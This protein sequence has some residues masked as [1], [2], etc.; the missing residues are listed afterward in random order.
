MAK[1]KAELEA[2]SYRHRA[3]VAEARAELQRGEFQKA[4]QTAVSAWQHVD[5]MMQ[6][7]RRW[8]SKS[9]FETVD[10]IALVLRYAPLLFDSDSLE[11]L[12]TLLKS[13][14][15]IDKNAAADI[16]A[17]L[18]SA[19]TLMWDAHRL[20]T[21]LEEHAEVRQDE[22]RRKLGGDQD[23]WR[24]IAES[25]DRMGLIQRT[26]AGGSYRLMFTTRITA[27]MRGKCPSC[28]VNGKAAMAYFL[29][30]ITCPKCGATSS[31]IFLSV[32]DR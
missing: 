31:F 17:D 27:E 29:E 22:L 25:W 7:D 10:C 16:A 3:L 23:N 5:G 11:Q 14:R 24:R 12:A 8:G 1:T 6:Y 15:R 4:V 13:Q 20:W 32:A 9:E 21:Y 19:K 2:D 18:E 28:G 26:A 30:E